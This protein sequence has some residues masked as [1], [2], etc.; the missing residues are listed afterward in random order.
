VAGVVVAR[1]AAIRA[2]LAAYLSKDHSWAL[3]LS[4]EISIL[5]QL[6]RDLSDAESI[7]KE[8]YKL[9]TLVRRN[10]KELTQRYKCEWLD[11]P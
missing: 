8:E 2:V 9:P 1:L 5:E 4:D 11:L 6:E 3:A 7:T 10:L